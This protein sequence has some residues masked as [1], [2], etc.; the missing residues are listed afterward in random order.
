MT[1]TRDLFRSGLMSDIRYVVRRLRASPGFT[2]AAVLSLAIGIGANTAV[3]SAARATLFEMLPV[4]RP[5]ELWFVFWGPR[6]PPLDGMYRDGDSDPAT[7]Q[8]IVSNV[9]YPAYEQIRA[10]AGETAS[11]GAFTYM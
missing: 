8:R 1:V 7:G 4:D 2:A 9:T 10:P 3:A 6:L 5:G 11:V